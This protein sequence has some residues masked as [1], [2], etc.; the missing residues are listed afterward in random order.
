MDVLLQVA[1]ARYRS[2]LG[3][4]CEVCPRPSLTPIPGA[5]AWL[6]GLMLAKEQVIPVV[7]LAR[8]LERPEPQRSGAATG[9][10][11]AVATRMLISRAGGL[12]VGFLVDDVG[13]EA[14]SPGLPA[15]DLASLASTL[16][17]RLHAAFARP[18]SA[19]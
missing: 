11:D 16:V 15:V 2:R 6:A 12:C 7:D 3:P 10:D 19:A 9:L 4:R 8:A 13:R 17:H 14:A 18:V 1:S 5:P